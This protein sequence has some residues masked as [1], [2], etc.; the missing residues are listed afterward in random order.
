MTLL[1]AVIYYKQKDTKQN[2]ESKHAEESTC[3][4]R[5]CRFDPWITNIPWRRKWQPIPVFLPGK[6]RGQEEPAGVQ[7]VLGVGKELDST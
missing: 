3:Q 2:Q 6:S 5:I 4:C 1:G 7:S